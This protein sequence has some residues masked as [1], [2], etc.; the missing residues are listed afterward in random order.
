MSWSTGDL[1]PVDGDLHQLLAV[2]QRAVRSA[3]FEQL[4]LDPSAVL[5]EVRLDI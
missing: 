2:V 5:V 3:A 1:L 4:A